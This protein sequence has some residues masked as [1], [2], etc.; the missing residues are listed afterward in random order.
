MEEAAQA[1]RAM[2]A[3][4]RGALAENRF[5][6]HFQPVVRLSDRQV[7]AFEALLR[8]DRP[9][10]G[11]VPPAEFVPLAEECGL[12]VPLGHWVLHAACSEATHWP[13]P[14]RVAVNISAAQ[15][16][17]PSLVASVRSAI[18]DAGLDP[19]RLE[20]E[21][22][23][24]LLLRDSQEVMA[25][26][27]ALKALGVGISMDDFGTGYSSL[28][29]LTKFPF[30]TLKIDQSFVRDMPLRADCRAIVHAVTGLCR[31]L[32]ITTIAEGVETV[33]QLHGVLAEG[34]D[35]AQGFLFSRAV[36]A[37]AVAALLAGGR[38]F[39]AA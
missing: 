6:L 28:S 26:L 34:C 22:T 17:S 35:Q 16:A 10:H 8:W 33:E 29:Y 4:L 12:I 2:E 31:S 20:L 24:T 7:C 11:P 39:A 36:P 18:A 37:E 25:T 21:I 27:L 19:P 3:D 1:R 15:F 38:Q 14:A 9:G 30:D 32:G 13:A 5:H 23:E